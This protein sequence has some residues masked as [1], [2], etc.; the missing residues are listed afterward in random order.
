MLSKGD[1]S[2]RLN[3][4]SAGEREV[5]SQEF[6][7]RAESLEKSYIEIHRKAEENACL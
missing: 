4:K 7:R 3:L 2:F 1:I 6:N 5:L